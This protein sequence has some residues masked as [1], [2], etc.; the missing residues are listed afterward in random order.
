MIVHVKAFDYEKSHVNTPGTT[1]LQLICV[2]VGTKHAY[3]FT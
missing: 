3:I 2:L 1:Y